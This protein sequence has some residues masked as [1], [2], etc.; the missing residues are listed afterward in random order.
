LFIEPIEEPVPEHDFYEIAIG[1]Y[2]YS[3]ATNITSITILIA[4]FVPHQS[5]DLR[6]IE[7]N[8]FTT[9]F[10]QLIPEL[11]LADQGIVYMSRSGDT[12]PPTYD[13]SKLN[14][15]IRCHIDN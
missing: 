4:E 7:G 11:D 15:G 2:S 6:F 3:A 5:N 13:S 1:A 8:K 12:N 9:P 10:S 14:I